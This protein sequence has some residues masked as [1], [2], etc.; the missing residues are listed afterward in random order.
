M[1]QPLVL[2]FTIWPS[3]IWLVWFLFL[4]ILVVLCPHVLALYCLCIKKIP[5]ITS[6]DPCFGYCENDQ[7][8]SKIHT[9]FVWSTILNIG[10]GWLSKKFTH[11]VLCM[12]LM[13]KLVLS[14]RFDV[15]SFLFKQDSL[16]LR[17][18]SLPC[19]FSHVENMAGSKKLRVSEVRLHA[20]FVWI[21]TR[22]RSTQTF[23]MYHTIQRYAS[24]QWG[25][26]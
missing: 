5:L 13:N 3:N 16:M 10:R 26:A 1:E 11:V 22:K 6:L 12:W 25:W 24:I 4:C 19:I 17:M 9:M 21:D 7:V 14:T 18:W 15:L 8:C 20:T 2:M 23:Y